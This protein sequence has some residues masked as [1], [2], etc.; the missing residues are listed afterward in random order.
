MILPVVI[1]G[2][3]SGYD[4]LTTGGIVSFLEFAKRLIFVI[5]NLWF[6]Y[7]EFE[8]CRSIVCKFYVYDVTT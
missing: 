6:A 2:G 5:A 1:V 3:Y 7:Y 4:I 8:I